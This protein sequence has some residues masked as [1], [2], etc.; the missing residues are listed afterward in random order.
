MLNSYHRG[1]SWTDSLNTG[2]RN[3]LSNAHISVEI[4]IEDI[5]YKRFSK[6]KVLTQMYGL[7]K[8]KYQGTAIDLVFVTDNDAL[9][10]MEQ[11]GDSL[12]PGTPVVFCGINNRYSFK[13]GFT[14]V[15]EEVD[16]KSNLDLIQNFHPTLSDLHVIIDRTTTEIGRAHV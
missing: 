13:K 10:F 14:G 2:I 7:L 16:I 4:Y 15:L 3:S 1:L 5:D 12:F 6:P 11:H 9:L 8:M